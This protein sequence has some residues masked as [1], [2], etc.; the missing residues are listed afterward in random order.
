MPSFRPTARFRLVGNT[1]ML[2][3]S[4]PTAPIMAGSARQIQNRYDLRPPI[5]DR[6]DR[7]RLNPRPA[8]PAAPTFLRRLTV[9]IRVRSSPHAEPE[10]IG[11]DGDGNDGGLAHRAWFPAGK[12]DVD[13]RMDAVKD[14][15]EQPFPCVA[16]LTG[17]A[18][19]LRRA[20]DSDRRFEGTIPKTPLPGRRTSLPRRRKSITVTVRPAFCHGRSHVWL[21]AIHAPSSGG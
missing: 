5:R 21:G 9:R 1:V 13:I 12:I 16:A 4:L 18:C 7:D 8:A 3:A 19:L 6:H 15:G 17:I 20:F 11:D 2:S 14:L 10:A